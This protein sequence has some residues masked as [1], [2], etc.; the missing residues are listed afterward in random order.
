MNIFSTSPISEEIDLFHRCGDSKLVF[1]CIRY[2]DIFSLEELKKKKILVH[3]ILE[4][5]TNG[6][7]CI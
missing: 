1:T 6:S 2:V 3:N 7:I 4:R 5:F